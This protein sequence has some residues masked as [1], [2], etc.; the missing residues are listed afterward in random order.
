MT[1]SSDR[2][3]SC[4]DQ[5]HCV[6]SLS[7]YGV[8]RCTRVRTLEML[9]DGIPRYRLRARCSP[10]CSPQVQRGSVGNEASYCRSC[11]RERALHRFFAPS[12][13]VKLVKCTVMKRYG[14]HYV[15]EPGR[16]APTPE[17]VFHAL[18]ITPGERPELWS[19]LTRITQR[20]AGW[21]LVAAP[22]NLG[23][24]PLEVALL[25]RLCAAHGVS[26]RI[27][28]PSTEVVA[29]PSATSPLRVYRTTADFAE[30]AKEL[31]RIRPGR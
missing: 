3:G 22:Y 8:V 17:A 10:S 21:I 2:R 14:G 27:V 13:C 4:C 9:Y 19:L 7:A 24:T 6:Q 11:T 1:R 23:A 18:G 5:L 29:E 15:A 31:L 25:L 30:L 12:G 20:T 28:S 16:P 26:I